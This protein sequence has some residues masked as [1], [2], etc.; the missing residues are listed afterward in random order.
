MFLIFYVS[1]IVICYLLYNEICVFRGFMN[2]SEEFRSKVAVLESQLDVLLTERAHLDSLLKEC[3]FAEGIPT[4]M[5]T[6]EELVESGELG[7]SDGWI[8]S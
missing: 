5:K 3:G 4:L 6:I 8:A 7:P 2:S 1:L